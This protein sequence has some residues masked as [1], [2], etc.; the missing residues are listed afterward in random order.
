M[1][2]I[3]SGGKVVALCDE[4]RY[5]LKKASTGVYIRTDAEHAEGVVVGGIVY[6]IE[7]RP[8]I[9]EAAVAS[10]I[11]TDGAEFVFANYVPLRQY[12]AD[13]AAIEDALCE[14]DAAEFKVEVEG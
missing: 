2:R 11:Q 4:P 8:A 14:M 9:E 5:V 1:Y 13:L 3:V 10:V 12:S 7:G 6:S